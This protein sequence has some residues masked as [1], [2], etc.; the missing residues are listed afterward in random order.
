MDALSFSA[1]CDSNR[2]GAG[3]WHDSY[4]HVKSIK[5]WK[6]NAQDEGVRTV[7]NFMMKMKIIDN[8]DLLDNGIGALGRHLPACARIRLHTFKFS[9]FRSLVLRAQTQLAW[10]PLVFLFYVMRT[11]MQLPGLIRPF[12]TFALTPV[13]PE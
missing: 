12:L 7:C 2:G 5:L 10:S 3:H 1:N 9:R 11:A 13:S 6:V 8:L 4:K